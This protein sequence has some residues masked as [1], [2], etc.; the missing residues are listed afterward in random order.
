MTMAPKSFSRGMEL[1][2][3]TTTHIPAHHKVRPLRDHVV[4]EPLDGT[5]SAIIEVISESKPVKGV[6]RAVGPGCY[7]KRYD[8][9]EKHRRTK[10]WDSKALRPCDVKVGDTVGF[11]SFA[12][13]TF[14]WGEKLC[15]ILREEDVTGIYAAA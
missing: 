6:V 14:Y 13:Q 3:K 10:M 7:P 12:F 5:L 2:H 11:G 8:H 9:P 4:V 1:S 15:L